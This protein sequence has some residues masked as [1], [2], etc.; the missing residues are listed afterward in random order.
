MEFT[1]EHPRV[2]YNHRGPGVSKLF[3]GACSSKLI[4]NYF[5]VCLFEINTPT[6][7]FKPK[8]VDKQRKTQKGDDEIFHYDTKEAEKSPDN[9]IIHLKSVKLFFIYLLTLK[10]FLYAFSLS[11][12]KI[13]LKNCWDDEKPK[14]WVKLK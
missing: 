7:N 13:L 8:D 11:C 4:L 3:F 2:P 14:A 10:G 12:K 6:L 9:E 1:Y 5:E